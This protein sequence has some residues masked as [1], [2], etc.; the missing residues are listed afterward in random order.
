MHDF[1][2][3]SSIEG[4]G[5]AGYFSIRGIEFMRKIECSEFDKYG[6]LLHLAN[7]ILTAAPCQSFLHVY[8]MP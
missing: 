3:S 6:D 2:G 7:L 8:L 5:G 1:E 4:W